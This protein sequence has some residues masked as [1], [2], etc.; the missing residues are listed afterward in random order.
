[1]KHTVVFYARRIVAALAVMF[2]FGTAVQAQAVDNQKNNN[3]GTNVEYV[4]FVGVSATKTYPEGNQVTYV[5]ATG[6]PANE[7]LAK[8]TASH[9]VKMMRVTRVKIYQDRD[10]FLLDADADVNPQHVVDEMNI[11]LNDY[12]NRKNKDLNRE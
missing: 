3:E 6:L 9:V 4:K 10:E 2:L 12:Y 7:S 5:M 1:M 11:F 8:M